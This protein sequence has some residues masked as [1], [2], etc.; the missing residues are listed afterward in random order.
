MK[1]QIGMSYLVLSVEW[2]KNE[3]NWFKICPEI[4]CRQTTYGRDKIKIVKMQTDK[5]HSVMYRKTKI[6]FK[7]D[8]ILFRPIFLLKFKPLF[9]VLFFSANIIE[10][11]TYDY[12]SQPQFK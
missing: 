8:K 6:L 3:I 7:R 11:Q 10:V 5:L 2:R 9:L 4:K 1:N 12:P